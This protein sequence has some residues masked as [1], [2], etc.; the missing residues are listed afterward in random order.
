MRNPLSLEGR[1]ERLSMPEPNSGC[2][3][4]LAAHDRNGYGFI[5]VA[6]KQYRA[7]RVAYE[8]YRGPIPSGLVI[9]HLCRNPACVNPNHLEA[10]SVRE[11]TLRGV[12]PA[13]HAARQ[14]VCKRG[15]S[16]EG[17]NLGR[18]Y[19]GRRFCRSCQRMHV[20]KHRA[21]HPQIRDYK[22]EWARRAA[23]A[24]QLALSGA[25]EERT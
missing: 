6:G 11:N 14:T 10:V 2:W 12:S 17:E 3:L 16:M 4:W 22:A 5:S 15:H 13:A 23:R 21:A 24:R 1:I 19:R 8:A 25:M 20:R 18:D 9:D 7:H